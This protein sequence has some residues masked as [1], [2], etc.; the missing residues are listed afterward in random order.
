[1]I[2]IKNK[3][4]CC[5]CSACQQVCPKQCITLTADKEGFLYPSVDIEACTNC[6]LCEKVCPV[7]N[8]FKSSSNPVSYACK[9]NDERIRS[10]S[11]S[12]GAFSAL[13]EKIIEERGVVFGAKFTED[14]S[15]VHGFSE[16]FDGI[17]LF[18][19]SK[20][21]QSSMGNTFKNVKAFLKQG[22]KVLFTGTPCQVSG[23]NHYLQKEYDNLITIDIVCHSIASPSVWQKYIDEISQGRQISQLT[24]RDK[25]LGWHSYA[26]K[27]LGTDLS[28][29]EV[30][31]DHGAQI[32]NPYMRGFLEDL[33]VRPSCSC[34]PARNYV[35]GSDI[36][37][38]DF[39]RMEKYHPDWDDNKGM[40]L[41]IVLTNKGQELLDSCKSK[42]FCK[43]V[44]YS[45]VE[46]RG[47]HAPITSST[48][49]HPFHKYFF[50]H[51]MEVPIIQL[52]NECLKKND[53]KK[54]RKKQVSEFLRTTGLIYILRICKKIIR[55]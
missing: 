13:A 4:E 6:H 49:L 46:D 31:L 20:Y 30:V 38:A 55:K 28:G 37:L 15:V 53:I 1:M 34:C 32:E 19:G 43:H 26:L 16:S 47:V 45:E 25:S 39:W 24:F 8:K 17:N 35:S 14:W 50:K 40:S 48:P 7:I 3:I 18:R 41:V 2:Y 33:T 9:N 42:M 22:R 54:K 52:L 23:L 29:S 36:M 5:G 51:Y 44:P 11:S 27:I 12:G 10:I 21:V